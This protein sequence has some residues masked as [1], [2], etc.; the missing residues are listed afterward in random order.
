MT[1]EAHPTQFIADALT[2]REN[3]G[4]VRGLTVVFM[5]D[6]KNNVANSLM[7]G[8]AKLGM[9]YVACCPEAD[10][11]DSELVEKCRAIAAENDCTVTVT[12]DV[13]EGT[14]G[15]HALSACIPR[16]QNHGSSGDRRKVRTCRNGS[17]RRGL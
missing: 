5:G 14:K 9:N 3:F 8:C 6:A 7:V 1:T 17:Y 15:A 2:I 4:D 10:A 16:H 11:P 13:D 12:S